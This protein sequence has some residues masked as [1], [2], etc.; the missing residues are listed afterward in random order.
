MQFH[1][2]M[3]DIEYAEYRNLDGYN[4]VDNEIIA[5][6]PKLR[7]YKGHKIA[8]D[9]KYTTIRGECPFCHVKI[10]KEVDLQKVM[11]VLTYPG[12]DNGKDDQCGMSEIYEN[13][14]STIMDTPDVCI[15]LS[16]IPDDY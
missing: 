8:Y 2:T 12:P 9:Y 13:I 4:I 15:S 10:E 11:T 14:F 16:S 1:F 3:D 5:L 7:K 6:C